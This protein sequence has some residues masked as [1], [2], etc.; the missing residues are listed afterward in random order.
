MQK[1]TNFGRVSLFMKAESRYAPCCIASRYNPFLLINLEILVIL[2]IDHLSM[3]R[4]E[5]DSFGWSFVGDG[6][7]VDKAPNTE[8]RTTFV[9]PVHKLVSCW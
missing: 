8:S 2:L 4:M 3:V 7:S 6:V 9:T 5:I 1:G